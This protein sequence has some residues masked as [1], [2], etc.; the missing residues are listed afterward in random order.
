MMHCDLFDRAL[1]KLLL[2]KMKFLIYLSYALYCVNEAT[3]YYNC[4]IA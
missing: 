4:Q 2:R 1:I 3:V